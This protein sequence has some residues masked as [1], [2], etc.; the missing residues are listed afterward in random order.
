MVFIYILVALA[1]ILA[2]FL[3]I[4]AMRPSEFQITRSADIAAP[5]PVVFA[6]V[7][8]LHKWEAW[9]PWAKLDPTMKQTY[10]GAPAGTG[11][12]YRWDGNKNVG[13][14]RMTIVESRPSDLVRIKLEFMRPFA[15]T[16]DVKLTFEPKNGG[17]N[18]T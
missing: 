9:S 7:N 6:E 3:V 12:I 1:I 18:M 17:T 16:N 5:P 4:V 14:G 2:V 13:E 10:D 11:A 8:D 15:G